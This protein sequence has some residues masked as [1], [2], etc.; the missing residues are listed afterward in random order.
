MSHPVYVFDPTQTDKLSSVRG[1]GRYLQI[2]KENF[3]K[4]WIFTDTLKRIPTDSTFINPFFNLLQPP[5]LMKRVAQKQIAVIHD[6]IP[7]KYPQHFPIGIKGKIDIFLNKL[8]LKNYDTIIT[9][10][11]AS[12]RDIVQFLDFPESKVKIVYPCLPKIFNNSEFRIQN[13]ELNLESRITF[14]I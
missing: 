3:G 13:S 5:L 9:D 2:L 6:V 10:S 1:I 14:S 12:K 8:A 7:F 4:T 11:E